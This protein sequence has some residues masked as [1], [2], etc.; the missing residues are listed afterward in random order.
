MILNENQKNM[1]KNCIFLNEGVIGTII[2][3]FMA[4]PFI[5]FAF[6]S[7]A[8]SISN[9]ND[10]RK[11]KNK[12]KYNLTK[13]IKFSEPINKTAKKISSIKQI[14][15][16]ELCKLI[17]V[18]DYKTKFPNAQYEEIKI[19]GIFDSNNRL[20]AY[21]IL[22]TDSYKFIPGIIDNEVKSNKEST[23]FTVALLEYHLDVMGKGFKELEN[24]V[25]NLNNKNANSSSSSLYKKV[26]KKEDKEDIVEN[27]EKEDV[28][29]LCKQLSEINEILY[30]RIKSSK[31][32]NNVYKPSGVDED[33]IKNKEKIE[34]I[35]KT[36]LDN[37]MLNQKD[38]RKG[39]WTLNRNYSLIFNLVSWNVDTLL[40]DENSHPKKDYNKNEMLVRNDIKNNILFKD[41]LK[42]SKDKYSSDSYTK[43]YLHVIFSNYYDDSDNDCNEKYIL[44]NPR[45]LNIKVKNDN[46]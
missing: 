37:K 7:V 18:K 32:Y 14:S 27:M 20:I 26:S 23:I 2:A 13:A 46:N 11:M 36:L 34:K 22:E 12:V 19:K 30:K 10:K 28:V 33:Y 35:R 8:V 45:K 15:I 44:F 17:N 40:M 39:Y 38:K 3:L 24:L 16:W 6:V 31:F 5:I 9:A 21:G 25:K 42:I 4:F 41:L 29:E 1:Y 43:K